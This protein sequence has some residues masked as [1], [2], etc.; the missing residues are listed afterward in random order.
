MLIAESVPSQAEIEAR[1]A[2]LRDEPQGSIP[3]TREMEARLAALQDRVPSSQT[4][5]WVSAVALEDRD[6]ATGPSR[7]PDASILYIL[8]EYLVL[9]RPAA[10]PGNQG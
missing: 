4:P 6:P 9:L 7:S 5:Q 8:Q 1:L 2:A 3:A 10:R